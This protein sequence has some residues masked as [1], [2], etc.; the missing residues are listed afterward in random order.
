MRPWVR[1][2]GGKVICGHLCSMQADCADMEMSTG[3]KT[4]VSEWELQVVVNWRALVL[5]RS[6]CSC[7]RSHCT[8]LCVAHLCASAP[9]SQHVGLFFCSVSLPFSSPPPSFSSASIVGCSSEML[10]ADFSTVSSCVLDVVQE[11]SL[12]SHVEFS[13]RS[14]GT[15]WPSLVNLVSQ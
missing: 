8:S 7:C 6:S 15:L 13:A 12:K 1:L 3:S 2:G 11:R 9:W 10:S 4:T 14:R 5:D